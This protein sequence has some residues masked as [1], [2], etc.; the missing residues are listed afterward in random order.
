MLDSW[1]KNEVG[2]CLFESS[3]RV[4]E[5]GDQVSICGKAVTLPV[6]ILERESVCVL[7]GFTATY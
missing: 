6:A 1:L 3:R 2:S 4:P 7:E 5:Q